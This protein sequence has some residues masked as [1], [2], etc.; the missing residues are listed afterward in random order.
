MNVIFSTEKSGETSIGRILAIFNLGNNGRHCLSQEPVAARVQY[1]RVSTSE[2]LL[3]LF[4]SPTSLSLSTPFT[5]FALGATVSLSDHL[6]FSD[7][8]CLGF[9]PLHDALLS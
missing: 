4:V 7:L 9:R 5:I 1:Q 3:Q 2:S 6:N 8:P